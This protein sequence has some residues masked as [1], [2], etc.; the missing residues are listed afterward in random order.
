MI[1]VLQWNVYWHFWIRFLWQRISGG[2]RK[3]GA[4]PENLNHR[5]PVIPPTQAW[6]QKKTVPPNWQMHRTKWAFVKICWQ[7]TL[8]CI[9]LA[10]SKKVPEGSSSQSFAQNKMA[11]C[12]SLLTKQFSI[13]LICSKKVPEGTSGQS[14][15][16]NKM[17][18]C[19][20]LFA[21]KKIICV[22]FLARPCN[23]AARVCDTK[24]VENFLNL[25]LSPLTWWWTLCTMS[26]RWAHDE[27]KNVHDELKMRKKTCMMSFRWEKK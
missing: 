5:G 25:H 4:G 2:P 12:E 21:F 8:S 17:A 19:E 9:K 15:A 7:N 6:S 16:Q 10:C 24:E 22:L 3:M 13:K 11:I 20:S 27:K 23:A 26:S 14:F 18:I 1:K